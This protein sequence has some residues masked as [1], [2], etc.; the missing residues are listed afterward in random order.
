VIGRGAALYPLALVLTMPMTS[1]AVPPIRTRTDAV[2]DILHGVKVADPYRW[3]EDGAS[4]DT[5]AWTTAQNAQTR[6]ILDAIPGRAALEGRLWSLYEIGSLGAP[7][8]RPLRRGRARQWRYFYTRRDGKQNQPVLYARDGL[9]GADRVVVDVNALATDGTRSLDWWFPSEDGR[10]VAYGVSADGSEESTLR[11]REVATGRDLAD[12]I[13]RTRACSVAWLPDG[14]GL[15]YTRYP[16]V[17]TVPLGEETYHRK[18]FFH[19]LGGDPATDPIVFG[20]ERDLKD[21]PT[22]ALS[23]DGRFL[24][25]EVS[26]GW[27]KSEVHIIDRAAAAATAVLVT[28]A[29]ENAIFDLSEITDD[30]L[31]IRSNQD[32]PRYRLYRVPLPRA[33]R[34]RRTP[35]ERAP[36][37]PAV[38]TAPS[39]APPPSPS[40]PA[41]SSWHELIAEGP[42][43]LEQVALVGKTIAALYLSDASSRVRLFDLDGHATGAVALPAL[44]SVA[45]LSGHLEGSEL[46]LPFTSFLTPTAVLRQALADAP[47]RES[48]RGPR[49]L[50]PPALGRADATAAVTVPRDARKPAT[51]LG[52]EPASLTPTVWRAIASPVS[53]DAY[54][55]TQDRARSKDGTAVPVFLVHRKDLPRDGSAPTVLTGY[56]GFNVNITPGWAPSMVPFLEAGGVYAVA[57][58]RGGGEY[59]ETWHRAGMLDQKQNVFDDFIAAAEHLIAEK[60]T[61]PDRLAIMG[62]SN[63]GLLV[64]AALTQR[65][66]LFRAVIAGVPLMD[67]LRYHRFRIAQLWIPEYG[68]A[69]DAAAFPWLLAYSPYHRVRDGVAYPA[70]MLVTAAS[71]TRVDPLHARKMAARL[72]A[73][74]SSPR[75]VLLRIETQ[76]GHGAGK[77]LAKV[78]EEEADMLAF[79]AKQG[80]GAGG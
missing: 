61:R 76:A 57:V 43:P 2:V 30:A 59:G 77:P 64:G 39:T 69:D 46:F 55:V 9:D 35:P 45:G 37:A 66:E 67:M 71:D 5:V 17:G 47:A 74:T 16:A 15:Y 54:V 79:L 23:P 1:L 70:V 41:R 4:P 7:V 13:D 60:R 12:A 27:S 52:A 32:A 73:A 24:G 65:P 21:W 62:R 26:Q 20:N 80:L 25:I 58:L 6:R 3:L 28:P 50:A 72:Q 36:G 53:A 22:V 44:G 18:V 49:P 10:L 19:R 8:P 31:L 42:S 48:R 51:S 29:G 34:G 75:P 40:P 78:I 33:P 38:A 14:S 11:V 68:S 56:G 63:G